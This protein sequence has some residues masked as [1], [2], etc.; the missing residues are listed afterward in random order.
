[1][2]AYLLLKFAHV[3]S[4]AVLLGTGIGI[5]FFV[6]WANAKGNV[7]TIA[8]TLRGVLVADAV[9]TAIAAVAQPVTGLLLVR[10]AGYGFA[11]RWVAVSLLLYVV[12][13]TCWLPVVGLQRRMS[14]L[15]AKAAT[16]GVRLPPVYH[17]LLRVWFWLGWP[18]LFALLIMYWLML[19]KPA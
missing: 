1:M 16:E 14:T 8:T 13:V 2:D 12:M 18:A 9:F 4:G 15:A 17:R 19:A 5:A 6:L 11:D 7:A 10:L 3:L